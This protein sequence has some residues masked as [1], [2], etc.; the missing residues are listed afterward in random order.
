MQLGFVC[1][2]VFF[3]LSPEPITGQSTDK[4][5]GFVRDSQSSAPVAGAVV[6]LVGTNY[7]DI[8]DER[9]F[10]RFEHLP[11]GTYSVVV[12]SIG[13]R[14]RRIEQVGV[15]QDVTAR[16]DITLEAKPIPLPPQEVKGLGPASK[17][18]STQDVTIISHKEIERSGAGSLAELFQTVPGLFVYQNG[19]ASGEKALSVRGSAANQVVILVN[20]QRLASGATG[21]A[22]LA[23]IPLAIVERVEVVKGGQAARIGPDALAGVINIITRTVSGKRTVVEVTGRVGSFRTQEGEVTFGRQLTERWQVTG[24]AW[25]QATAGDF[26]Y[27]DSLGQVFLRENA[28]REAA[29][30]YASAS[31]N[32]FRGGNLQFSL[33][34]YETG[35]GIPGALLQFTPAATR[36]EQRTL[37][38][39]AWNQPV[40]DHFQME[41][42][43]SLQRYRQVFQNSETP[44]LFSRYWAAT[45][46]D[47][48]QISGRWNWSPLRDLVLSFGS[49]YLS[50][51]FTSTDLLRPHLSLGKAPR[52]ETIGFFLAGEAKLEHPW[53]PL[54]DLAVLSAAVRRDKTSGFSGATNPHVGL[55]LA[56]G[57]AW[58]ITAKGN[59]QRAYRNPAL[60]DLFWKEDALAV[61]NPQLKPERS[62]DWDAGGEVRLP[63]LGQ[64]TVGDTW[65]G[66]DVRDLVVWQRR[67]DGK[68]T[69]QNLIRAQISGREESFG[70][71]SRD[72]KIKAG[73]QHTYSRAVDRSGFRP[74]EGKQLVFRP[75]HVL[76]AW[77][78]FTWR[79]WS[80]ASSYRWVDRRF[81]REANTKSLPP[82]HLIDL[83]C[84]VTFP[85]KAGWEIR[86]AFKVTNL[87]NQAY[88]LL[89]RQ[90]MPGREWRFE[91]RFK[92]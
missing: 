64:V 82:Y 22:D 23:G 49:E 29:N 20:G 62:S 56:R 17:F 58:K 89:E 79:G 77:G 69:P 4:L 44:D 3:S 86:S 9:G 7:R 13:Y 33:Q 65:F 37:F 38:S 53:P 27:R 74:H 71:E 73:L 26:P 36:R 41:L 66:S 15:V 8:T 76:R 46:T 12:R 57:D 16:L 72:E 5:Q 24:S 19:S 84:G 42:A 60:V 80:L 75:R 32:L 25:A 85:R 90:P 50:G 68:Y 81:I 34:W 54:V 52:R 47:L 31:A 18:S 78:Q 11:V 51:Q 92:K 63:L 48:D 1:G 87:T 70:W 91:L 10:Y 39:A 14:T 83:T 88:E 2:V 61:G 6:E 59:W 67:F 40:T 45:R 28:A 43:G 30:F 55:L 21:T 35:N